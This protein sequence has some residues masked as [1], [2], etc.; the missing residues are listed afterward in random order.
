MGV[1]VG[2]QQR[3]GRRLAG[4]VGR[5]RDQ[6][7]PLVDELARLDAHPDDGIG[8]GEDKSADAVKTALLGQSSR[9]VNVDPERPQRIT[10]GAQHRGA[11]S[12][13]DG[14]RRRQG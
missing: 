10:D 13:M 5:E 9:R 8:G 1:V 11:G 6:R 14:K 3:F 2:G 12:Q 7:R 4:S